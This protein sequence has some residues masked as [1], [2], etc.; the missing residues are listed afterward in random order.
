MSKG[1]IIAVVAGV[2]IILG[3]AG[4]YFM[5][6]N[7]TS[8]P[9]SELVQNDPT[10]QNS[11]IGKVSEKMSLKSFLGSQASQKCNYNDLENLSSGTVYVGNGKVRGDFESKATGNNVLAHMISDGTKVFV[12]TDGT[13][14]GISFDVTKVEEWADNAQGSQSLDVNKEVEYSCSNWVVDQSQFS[15]PGDIEFTDFTE[16]AEQFGTILDQNDPSG[17]S[18][19]CAACEALSGEA[20]D[21]CLQALGC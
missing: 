17:E 4:F 2:I 12:W 18:S 1:L 3:G 6:K 14:Q 13:A 19:Q 16:L 11:D 5:N 9:V 8:K 10:S 7:Q 15:V 20:K 21:T